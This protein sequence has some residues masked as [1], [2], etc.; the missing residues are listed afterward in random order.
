MTFGHFKYE[1]AYEDC[2]NFED[3]KTIV[4]EYMIYYNY[5]RPQMHK[6]KMTPHEVECHLIC[7]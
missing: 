3:L 5:K 2:N 7:M 4:N 6:Q 1:V